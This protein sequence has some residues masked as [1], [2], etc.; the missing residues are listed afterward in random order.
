M[1]NPTQIREQ[2]PQMRRPQV[3][4]QDIKPANVFLGH[5]DPNFFPLYP[6]PKLGDF[7]L[8]QETWRNDTSDPI[9]YSDLPECTPPELKS[10]NRGR[11]DVPRRTTAANVCQIGLTIQYM[12]LAADVRMA[13]RSGRPTPR[14]ARGVHVPGGAFRNKTNWVYSQT[15][16]DAIRHCTDTDPEERPR[17]QE[18]IDLCRPQYNPHIKNMHHPQECGKMDKAP[19]WLI[20]PRVVDEYRLK[21]IW[22]GKE[23]EPEDDT[24]DSDDGSGGGGMSDSDGGSGGDMS[25]IEEETVWTPEMLARQLAREKEYRRKMLIEEGLPPDDPDEMRE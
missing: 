21:R 1:E 7:G 15:L 3:I 24:S 6:T 25:G 19:H 5:A 2:Y 9:M 16:M 4:H 17:P 13:Q 20:V 18:I 23:E 22:R 14:G 11:H 8:A 10:R 12:M